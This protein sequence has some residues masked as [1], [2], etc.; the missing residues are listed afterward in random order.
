[1]NPN[2]KETRFPQINQIPW[3]KVFK[4]GT[5]V[6]AVDFVSSLLQYDPSK[7]PNPLEA[8]ASPY[9]DELRVQNMR[10]PRPVGQSGK[11]ALPDHMFNFT[12]EEL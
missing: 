2:Y 5:D 12:K 9:F 4:P 1:M 3:Q 7:R 8:L 11:A 10:V 6:E